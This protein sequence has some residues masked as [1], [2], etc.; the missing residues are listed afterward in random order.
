MAYKSSDIV[1]L[2]S[3]GISAMHDLTQ[4][5][6]SDL[7]NALLNVLHYLWNA[8]GPEHIASIDEITEGLNWTTT[9]RTDFTREFQILVNERYVTISPA[10]LLRPELEQKGWN[11]ELANGR[12]IHEPDT[13]NYDDV[14]TAH[15]LAVDIRKVE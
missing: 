9:G 14:V 8:G 3:R 7:S 11:V 13:M 4:A 10:K 1:K 2:A 12:V 15:P 6:S 5:P